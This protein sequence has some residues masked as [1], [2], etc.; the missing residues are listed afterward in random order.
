MTNNFDND[1]SVFSIDPGSGALTEVPGSPFFAN[2]NP[3]QI[4]ITH[5]GK[6]V[7]TTN[8]GI[9]MV[10]G[11][12][13]SNGVLTKIPGSPFTSVPQG[14]A[15]AL[16]VDASD[17][18]LY[19][20][21]PSASNPPPNS[22]TVG[23][24]SGF[25]IDQNTGTLTTILGS[26][27][28]STEGSGP[29]AITVDPSGRF[30]YAVA[31]GSSFSIWCLE[32]TPTNGQLTAVLNSPFSLAAGGQFV[33]IDSSGSFLYIGSQS[34]TAIQAYTLNTST[35]VP[36]VITGSPFPIVSAPGAM[37]FSE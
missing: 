25:N 23:N 17:R 3:T 28:A 5:S 13:F 7:Y 36:T 4:L 9:G 11:F 35:G 30:V 24:I 29:T 31:P 2:Q 19:V 20:T 18:F 8:P 14:G 1:I 21:N 10:T 33:L 16:A 26:P 12:S 27:F 37:V 6:F 22:I 15:S 34:A 32:I